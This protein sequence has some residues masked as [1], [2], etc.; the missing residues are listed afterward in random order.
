MTGRRPDAR[1]G[2]R[3]EGGDSGSGG[4]PGPNDEAR[5]QPRREDT[6]GAILGRV[7]AAQGIAERVAQQLVIPEWGALVGPQIARVTLPQ[8]VR[9][10]G[11]LV[12][13]VTT[14]AWMHE[15]SLLEPQLLARL[16]G[17]EGRPPIRR[18]YWVLARPDEPVAGADRGP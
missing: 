1:G 5:G 6:V 15:L 17:V 16:N 13:A 8:H 2:T 11:T 3:R 12:V 18:L 9:G 4:G 7:L 14:H 10:D